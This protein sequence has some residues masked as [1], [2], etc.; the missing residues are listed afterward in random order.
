MK[1]CIVLFTLVLF[2]F[3]ISAVAAKKK[4]PIEKIKYPE[5]NKFELPDIKKVE[6]NNGMK[7]RLI[8]TEKLPLIDLRMVIRGGDVYDPAPK[9]GLV[10]VLAQLIRIGGTKEMKGDAVDKFL[11]SNGITVSVSS[12]TNYYTVSL[13]CLKENFDPAISI[14][15]KR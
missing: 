7:L 15:S 9:V 2:L 14:L 8:K 4:R 5:L 12:R 3:N 11:D 10:G 13:T 6:L 1:K